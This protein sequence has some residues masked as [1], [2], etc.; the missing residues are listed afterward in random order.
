MYWKELTSKL[1]QSIQHAH[2]SIAYKHYIYTFVT[3]R[4]NI[5]FILRFNTFTQTW[6]CIEDSNRPSTNAHCG[7]V[8]HD[9]VYIFDGVLYRFH[10]LRNC[11]EKLQ[12]FGASQPPNVMSGISIVLYDKCL[13]TF[14]GVCWHHE[15]WNKMYQLSLETMTWECV[16]TKIAPKGRAHHSS[17]VYNG[18]MFVFGGISFGIQ[19]SF[20]K[21]DFSS[22]VWT[23]L[24]LKGDVIVPTF[25][26]SSVVWN[27]K[28]YMFGGDSGRKCENSFYEIDLE[29][30]Y[31]KRLQPGGDLPRERRFHNAV[32]VGESMY[33]MFGEDSSRRCAQRLVKNCS[34]IIM[35][36]TEWS[37]GLIKAL[38]RK[39]LSDIDFVNG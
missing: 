11:W 8:Y 33:I 37:N 9:C 6:Q 18:C 39:H 14:G 7:V 19:N 34:M 38:G 13:W 22:K 21:F 31:C 2:F 25:G 5:K 36:N 23:E 30:N 17:V 10:L 35:G 26:H 20:W 27:G 28:M 16:E 4:S 12:T 29:T 15:V 3:S 1:N 24:T 32:I